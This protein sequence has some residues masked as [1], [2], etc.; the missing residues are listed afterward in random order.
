M[1]TG[2]CNSSRKMEMKTIKKSVLP[3]TSSI[4]TARAEQAILEKLPV[5]E[6]TLRLI[7]RI[8]EPQNLK[9]IGIAAVGGSALISVISSIT[10]D[11]VYQA[12]VARE[13]KKQLVPLERRMAELEAQNEAL[14]EQNR[15]L[16]AQLDQK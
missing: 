9:Y 8:F 12:A 15:K 6:K 1:F 11:R 7:G 16:L 13:L 4:L 5:D 2:K 14:L 10:H 3:D